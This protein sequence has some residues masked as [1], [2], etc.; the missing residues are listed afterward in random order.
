MQ[1]VVWRGMADGTDSNWFYVQTHNDIVYV[2]KLA[3]SIFVYS[4]DHAAYLEKY[5]KV[6]CT[7]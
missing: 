2:K 5:Q 4:N 7:P 3:S 6:F 1:F